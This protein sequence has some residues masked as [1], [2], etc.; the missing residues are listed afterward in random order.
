MN[1]DSLVRN[2]ENYIKRE[3]KK[4]LWKNAVNQNTGTNVQS[5]C[6]FVFG[7]IAP[8]EPGPPH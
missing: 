2:E 4:K 8:N 7:A 3:N 5:V 6:L 1:P